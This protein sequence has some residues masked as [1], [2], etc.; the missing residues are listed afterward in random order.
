[1]ATQP[2]TPI[3][4]KP[5]REYQEVKAPE[6]YKFARLGAEIEG[7][8]TSIEPKE[9]NGKI[10]KEYMF[11]LDNGERV[12]CLGT[13]DLDKKIDPRHLGHGMKVKYE[14]DDSSFQ[15]AGQSAM[16]VFK[17]MVDKNIAP[18]YEH[19]QQH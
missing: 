16:K 9:V 2:A 6:Q 1:M 14:A 17:V 13:N 3:S 8:L 5:R 15:K 11:A 18:G 10:V 7:V 12:T 19:L 4:G